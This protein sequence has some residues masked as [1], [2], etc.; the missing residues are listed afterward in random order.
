MLALLHQA[1]RH[2]PHAERFH[3]RVHKL[4]T[5]RFPGY[6]Q[7]PPAGDISIQ[8][9]LF[10]RGHRGSHVRNHDNIHLFRDRL[11]QCHF[12]KV[13]TLIN[14]RI[15]ERFIL[16][17]TIVVPVSFP[18]TIPFPVPFHETDKRQF[19]HQP[20]EGGRDFR[21]EGKTLNIIEYSQECLLPVV[22]FQ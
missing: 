9:C 1:P 17:E 6:Q 13:K 14:Q 19:H 8:I 16:S 22:S 15:A 20:F 18:D 10:I 4:L 11:I 5:T 7:I 3:Q 2:E 12:C 21:L